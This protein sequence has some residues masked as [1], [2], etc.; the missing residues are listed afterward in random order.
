MTIDLTDEDSL[1]W[2]ARGRQGATASQDDDAEPAV[3][4]TF[5]TKDAQAATRYSEGDKVEVNGTR[6]VVTEVRT[7]SFEGPD[8]DV[9]ASD[10][11][12]AYIVATVDGAVVARASDL[13]KSDWS[14]D[15]DDPTGDLAQQAEAMNVDPDAD[16]TLEAGDFDYPESWKEA[17]TPARL[18]LLDAWSSMGGQFDCGGGCCHGE[19]MQS[20]MSKRAAAQFCA[21]MKDKVLGGWEGW[22]KGGG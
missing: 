13:S 14:T 6:G 20:G 4:D 5:G 17:D 1:D 8:G 3:N 16:D 21:A 18:L 11:R 2:M 10:N 9:D 15:Q 19:M 7:S 22:R 12:P